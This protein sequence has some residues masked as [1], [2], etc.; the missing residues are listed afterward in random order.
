MKVII[1]QI[2]LFL[3]VFDVYSS[4]QDSIIYESDKVILI[5]NMT[6]K[7][8]TLKSKKKRKKIRNLLFVGIVDKKEFEVLNKNRNLYYL[9]ED[10]NKTVVRERR[11]TEVCGTVPHF[12]LTIAETDSSFQVYE[13]ETFY[14]QKGIPP[15]ITAEVSKKQADSIQFLNGTS[16]FWFTSNFNY[17]N[18]I[19]TNPKTII[20]FK[21]GFCSTLEHPEIKFDSIMYMNSYGFPIT[22]KN[23]NYGI[24]GVVS[25]QYKELGKFN[26]Y[27]AR[28][29]LPNGEIRYIDNSGNQY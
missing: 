16:K 26:F 6:S 27:L 2:L 15:V 13:D 24:L 22:A 9:D 11:I 28:V 14:D 4:D 12:V 8:F 20:L 5:Q 3:F 17:G 10:W 25:A 29:V 7:L 18:V 19:K 21:D 23:G 1:V